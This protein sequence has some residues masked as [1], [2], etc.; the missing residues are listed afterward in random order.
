MKASAANRA[1]APRG[2]PSLA[3]T[4]ISFDFDGVLARSPFGHGVLFPVLK[5]LAH[6]WAGRTGSDADEAHRRVRELASAEFRARTARGDHVSAYDWQDIVRVVAAAV[7]ERFDA[8]LAEMTREYGRALEQAGDRSLLY[9]S[10]AETLAALRARGA[11]L[12]LLTNGFRDYQLPMARA[13]GLE[14][15]FHAIFASDDLGAVKPRPEAFERAFGACP[16][17]RAARRFHIGD[18]LGQ[19]VAGARACGIFAVWIEWGLPEE[20]ARL[21]PLERARSPALEPVLR[22]RLEHE[23]SS[24]SLHGSGTVEPA[25][26]R[27]DA[28]IRSL[29]ELEPVVDGGARPPGT[30]AAARRPPS[31]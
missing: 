3:G 20:L 17:Q 23:R 19:D 15:C 21:G 11:C 1:G 14:G 5:E 31:A 25:S 29:E 26:V 30:A 27:P 4:A 18:T 2:L 13:L 28:V 24:G 7:G 12:L 9:P 8:S 10:A 16:P 6:A 22:A